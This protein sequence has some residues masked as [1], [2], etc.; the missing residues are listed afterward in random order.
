MHLV[1]QK[2]FVKLKSASHSTKTFYLYQVQMF[3]I[4]STY[5]N[6]FICTK[7][8][9]LLMPSA[10]SLNTKQKILGE[11]WGSLNT[12]QKQGFLYLPSTNYCLAPMLGAWYL[13]G[14]FNLPEKNT[15]LSICNYELWLVRRHS[16]VLFWL[17]IMKE[18]HRSSPVISEL[19]SLPQ[20][21]LLENLKCR[22]I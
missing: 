3:W 1:S 21:S 5:E 16:S 7:H 2:N 19:P 10:I 15:I 12:K 8:K 20:Y 4:P 17:K 11:T 13:K 6:L 18:L 9:I 14:A 22:F